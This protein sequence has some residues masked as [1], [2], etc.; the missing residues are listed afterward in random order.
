MLCVHACLASNIRMALTATLQPLLFKQAGF[1]PNVA[2]FVASGAT[3]FAQVIVVTLALFYINTVGRRTLFIIGGVSI[4][5]S[6]GII[7]CSASQQTASVRMA[8]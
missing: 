8:C 1:D 6:Q 2:S 3:G 5:V 4:G 7:G